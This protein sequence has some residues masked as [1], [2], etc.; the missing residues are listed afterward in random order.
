VTGAADPGRALYLYAITDARTGAPSQSAGIRGAPLAVVTHRDLAA[1]VSL[2]EGDGVKPTEAVLW[3]HERVC[4]AIMEAGP[5]LPARFGLLFRDERSLEA[6][7][8]ARYGELTTALA[9]VAGKVE[10]GVRVLRDNESVPEAAEAPAIGG[11]G[12]AYLRA[13]LRER[14][15]ADELADAVHEE[16][17]RLAAASRRQLSRAPAVILSAAYLVDR[18]STDQFRR[19]VEVLDSQYPDIALLCTGPWPPYNFV[20]ARDE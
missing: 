1:V 5:V 17:E 3:E 6:E 15:R 19:R 11:P 18:E 8:A 14:Q 20:G 10:L 13:L 9:H 16:L 4:E 12:T 7:L 2:S